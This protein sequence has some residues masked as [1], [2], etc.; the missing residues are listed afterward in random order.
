MT[1]EHLREAEQIV[2]IVSIQN[3]YNVADRKSETVVDL[4]EQESWPSCPGRRS[5][6]PTR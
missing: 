2:P 3:R 4:C 5:R 6:T 1:E